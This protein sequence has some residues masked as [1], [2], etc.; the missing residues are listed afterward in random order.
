MI[1]AFNKEKALVGAF[2]G[3]CE[4]SRAVC[5][6]VAVAGSRGPA[7]G[8]AGDTGQCGAEP[9]PVCRA[10]PARPHSDET[11]SY[12]DTIPCSRPPPPPPATPVTHETD[13][14]GG[15]PAPSVPARVARAQVPR[16]RPAPRQA[17]GAAIRSAAAT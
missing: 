10:A 16:P 17:R 13:G 2:S 7:P 12:S 3:H 6:C 14:G 15:R 5:G 4:T 1:G 9:G 11:P 8:S